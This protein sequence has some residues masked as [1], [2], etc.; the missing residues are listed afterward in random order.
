MARLLEVNVLFLSP[1]F[2]PQFWLFCAALRAEGI[3]VLGLGDGPAHELFPPAHAALHQYVSVP[4]MG[5]YA[6]RYDD[7]LRAVGYLVS[8]WGRID[9]V[10]S[11]NEYWLPLEARLRED[12]NIPGPRPSELARHRSK[13]GMAEIFQSVGVPCARGEK[14][15]SPGAI[16][17]FASRHGFPVVLKPDVGVGAAQTWRVDTQPELEALL[18]KVAPNYRVEV[19]DPGDVVSYD[20][21]T[22]R[23]GRIVYET[24]HVYSSGVMD[25]VNRG[26]DIF[27]YSRRQLPA[28]MVEMG[29]K[30][31]SAFA[32]RERFFHIEFFERPQGTFRALEINLRPPGGFT[33]DMMNYGSDIDIYAL[34]ARVIAGRDV[35]GFTFERKYHVAHAARRHHRLYRVPEHEL[36]ARLGDRL[37]VDREI[38][39]VLSGAM[40]NHMYLLRSPSEA[41]ILDG[42]HLVMDPPG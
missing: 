9:R 40:G 25:V 36:K 41:E 42:I 1:H 13:T 6:T 21:L 32:L 7:V 8:R 17:S 27:Y 23:E 16:R 15:E 33:T 3:N 19:F 34:W 2:P 11:L 22:D 20:G 10:E 14:V 26:L 4:A 39:W 29:R 18:P 35:S 28:A 38:P 37:V 24:G 30:I 5:D 31:V 12:F